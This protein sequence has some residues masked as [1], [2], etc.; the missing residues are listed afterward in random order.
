MDGCRLK[1]PFKG[2]THKFSFASTYPGLQ[3]RLGQSGL[4]K[5]EERLRTESICWNPG[6][7]SP[8]LQQQPSCSGRP[9]PLE[10]QQPEGKQE[11]QPQEGFFHFLWGLS[12]TDECRVTRSITEGDKQRVDPCHLRASSLKSEGINIWHHQRQIQKEK[13][14][15]NTRGYQDEIH[16][17][18][19]HD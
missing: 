13:A 15:V 16:C 7:A 1:D 6:T 9:L 19:L 11:P 5:P 2:P 17:G 18:L 10:Q 4:E 8:P 14:V 12:L 3:Q